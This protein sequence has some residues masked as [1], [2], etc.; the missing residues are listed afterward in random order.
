MVPT[1][2]QASCRCAG[3]NAEPVDQDIWRWREP[4]LFVWFWSSS[5][6][7][8]AA[9]FHYQLIPN[10]TTNTISLLC[11][12]RMQCWLMFE[13]LGCVLDTVGNC[14]MCLNYLHAAL[15]LCGSHKWMSN[16][17]KGVCLQRYKHKLELDMIFVNFGILLAHFRPPKLQ[18]TRDRTNDT[19]ISKGYRRGKPLPRDSGNGV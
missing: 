3:S 15:K 18:P 10:G 13:L 14:C 4:W 16:S 2:C 17:D 7:P 5:W 6:L 11:R 9:K 12:F 19:N 8:N 1:L